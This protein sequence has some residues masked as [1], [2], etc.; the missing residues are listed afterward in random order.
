MALDHPR[1][2]ADALRLL[3]PKRREQILQ[4]LPL[5]VPEGV[6]QGNRPPTAPSM[7]AA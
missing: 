3:E 6:R 7:A 1:L 4:D 5:G 2:A